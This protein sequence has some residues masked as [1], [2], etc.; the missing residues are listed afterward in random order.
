MN[1]SM[2]NKI[3]GRRV[4][5]SDEMALLSESDGASNSNSAIQ[6][7]PAVIDGF[8]IANA[9]RFVQVLRD[10]NIEGYIVFENDPKHY[11]FTPEADFIYLAS[12]H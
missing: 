5:S 7:D 2:K 10:K 9:R 6:T 11:D 12:V 1:I 8:V 3:Y 4:G